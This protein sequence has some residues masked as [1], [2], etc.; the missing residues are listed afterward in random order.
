MDA[1]FHGLL[2]NLDQLA[3]PFGM[4]L[5]IAGNAAKVGLDRLGRRSLQAKVSGNPFV[6]T[7]DL[8]EFALDF[9]QVAVRLLNRRRVPR[10]NAVEPVSIGSSHYSP[11][12]FSIPAC[13]A[14]FIPAAKARVRL[15]MPWGA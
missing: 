7:R 10:L 14:A 3:D 9:A 4:V 5:Q 6:D 12:S 15:C 13:F 2:A 11:S 1:A 8:F